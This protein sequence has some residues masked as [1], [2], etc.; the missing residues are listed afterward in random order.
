MTIRVVAE[1][2][3]SVLCARAFVYDEGKWEE[4][5][6]P[7]EA[8][9]PHINAHGSLW[10]RASRSPLEDLRQAIR[11]KNPSWKDGCRHKGAGLL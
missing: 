3:A 10:G 1:K 4:L 7:V 6:C 11:S 8:H 5:V 2:T 9:Q